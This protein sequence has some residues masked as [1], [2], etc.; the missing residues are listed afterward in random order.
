MVK[1]NREKMESPES[2]PSDQ[3]GSLIFWSDV[4]NGRSFEKE[5]SSEVI[6]LYLPK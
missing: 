2:G 5:I 6:I 1:L 4:N 3:R